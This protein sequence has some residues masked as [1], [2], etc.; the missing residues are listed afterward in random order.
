MDKHADHTQ[1]WRSFIRRAEALYAMASLVADSGTSGGMAGRE[2]AERAESSLAGKEYLDL[3]I[4]DDPSDTA[5]YLY[6]T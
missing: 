6:S 1:R 2:W 3:T 4:H 5:S